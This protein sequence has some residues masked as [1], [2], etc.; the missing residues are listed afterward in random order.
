MEAVLLLQDGTR[1]QGSGFGGRKTAVGEVVFQTAMT[2]YEEILTDPSYQGQIV[3]MT[4]PHIGNTGING[5]DGESDGPRV[6]GL[7]VREICRIPSSYR[8]RGSLDEYLRRHGICGLSDIDT[9]ALTRRI[10]EKGTMMGVLSTEG[11]SWT[12]LEEKL[13]IHG[14]AEKQDLVR[15][16]TL[17]ENRRTWTDRADAVWRDEKFHSLQ[18]TR[19]VAVLDFGVKHQ[20]LRL[21]TSLGWQVM[22]FTA[23]TTAED[24]L[25]WNPDG[26]FLSNGPGNPRL[27]SGIVKTVGFLAGRLPVFGICLGHQ[28]M[29]LALGAETF[30][31]KFGH[32]GANHPVIELSSGIVRITSQNHNYAVNPDSLTRTGFI[33]T[34]RNLNDQTVEGM[35]HR[36]LPLGSVQYHPEA[37][38]GPHDAFSLFMEFDRLMDLS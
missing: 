24:L 21:M 5:E 2:G 4:C 19:R 28:I 23:N 37:S 17:E 8:S 15:Q 6:R 14:A 10:R 27:L 20:I 26:I 1:Y 29:A 7:I 3:T 36:E 25:E 33:I 11:L 35:R 34:S 38:P 30:K 32:H 9:R 31:L 16:V 18:K 13:R 12:V 22:R